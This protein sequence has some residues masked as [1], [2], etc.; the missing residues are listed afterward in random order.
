MRLQVLLDQ[1]ETLSIRGET[2]K[3]VLRVTEDSRGVDWQTAFVAVRGAK[4]DGHRYAAGL[5]CAVVFAEE[6]VA[7]ALGVPVVLVPDARIAL[8]DCAR[9]LQGNPSHELALVGITGT[10]GKTTTCWILESMLR[11]AAKKVGLIGTTGHRANRKSLGSGYTTPPA[12]QWQALLREMRDSGCDVVAAEVSSIALDSRRVHGSRFEVG[13]FTN[14]SRD[15]LDYHGSMEAYTQAKTLLFSDYLAQGGHAVLPESC[16]E[17]ASVLADRPDLRVWRYGLHGGDVHVADMAL[18]VDGTHGRIR[19]PS[20]A[21]DFHFPLLGLHN[22]LNAL[23]AVACAL[24]LGT[25]I[26]AIQRGLSDVPLIPG[27]MQAVP[28][29]AGLQ[30]LVDFAHTPDAL[31]K[32]L[33][34]LRPFVS[35]RLIL[36]FGCGGDR[37]RGKRPDMGKVACAGADLVLATSDNPRSEDPQAILKA[38]RAGMNADARVVVDRGDAIAAAIAEAQPGDVVLIA[39]KGHEQT[40][41]IAGVHHD[42]DD[43]QVAAAVLESRV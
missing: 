39:G 32:A 30:V 7:P 13:V 25:S 28:N 31:E 12:P 24:A 19:T 33:A 18:K 42:F 23:G 20:G 40:Q 17:L 35:G 38:I 26:A 16:P 22:V 9:I 41:E 14:L 6:D 11:A 15:H 3:A 10:N 4:A 27:R 34:G 8:A 2:D 21:F 5:E 29:S 36:V 1:I 43:A 37:D